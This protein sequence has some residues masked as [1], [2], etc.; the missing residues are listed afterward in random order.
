MSELIS[1]VE[2]SIDLI[3]ANIMYASPNDED[4]LEKLIA[5]LISFYVELQDVPMSSS[6]RKSYAKTEALSMLRD[7]RGL[8]VSRFRGLLDNIKQQIINASIPYIED[9]QYTKR[10]LKIVAM[11]YRIIE[12]IPY[13]EAY[14][15]AFII[16]TR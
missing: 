2:E 9:G 5:L 11:L 7:I 10:I 4:N 13:T 3:K 8:D 12:R 6:L 15:K 14:S 16:L 1:V